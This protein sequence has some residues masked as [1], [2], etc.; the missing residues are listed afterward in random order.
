MMTSGFQFGFYQYSSSNPRCDS[1]LMLARRLKRDISERG[2]TVDGVL[3]QYGSH[4]THA[5][6][7][8][9]F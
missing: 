8:S 3:E 1:D 6:I 9:N 7:Y 4:I 2:R 5:L